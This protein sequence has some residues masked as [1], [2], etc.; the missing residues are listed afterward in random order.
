MGTV[1]M[2]RAGKLA[3]GVTTSG[4]PFKAP[5][6]VGDSP[7]LGAGLYVDQE[8]GGAVAT[9]V[10][11]EAMRVCASFQVVDL[12]R[13]GAEPAEACLGALERL[14]HAH[15]GAREKQLALAALRVDGVPG[16]AALQAG[17]AYA[18]FDGRE[19]ALVDVVPML[20]R[21]KETE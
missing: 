4:T 8:V 15:C 5:G 17:F 19:N 9:G 6:R 1:V 10:G 14:L 16:G 13:R 12:M 21:R 3:V 11:E 20:C 18:Y 2:D 7:I